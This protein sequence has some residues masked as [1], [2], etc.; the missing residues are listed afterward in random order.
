MSNER[1]RVLLGVLS[2][3]SRPMTLDELTESVAT[4]QSETV[5]PSPDTVEEVMVALHHKHLPMLS[6]LGIIAYD[7]KGQ[8]VEQ[9]V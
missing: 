6:S 2:E 1:R 5:D 4:Q 9:A 3:Q 8:Q 7:S